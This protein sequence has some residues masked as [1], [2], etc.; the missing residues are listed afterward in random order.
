MVCLAAYTKSLCTCLRA[1]VSMPEVRGVFP[2][3]VKS[4][5]KIWSKSASEETEGLEVVETLTYCGKLWVE[6]VRLPGCWFWMSFILGLSVCLCY[7][8]SIPGLCIHWADT[9]LVSW[10]Y[11]SGGRGLAFILALAVISRWSIISLSFISPWGF[12]SS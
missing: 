11:V 3:C 10:V 5:N 12:E 2:C 4:V 6:W 7:W 9:L 1:A 8:A